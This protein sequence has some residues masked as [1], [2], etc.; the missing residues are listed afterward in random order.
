MED[1]L[2]G[3]KAAR[4]AGMRCIAVS[5]GA[6]SKEELGNEY[7]DLI[8][9]SIG[10]TETILGFILKPHNSLPFDKCGALSSK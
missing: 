6:Y 3:M 10:E 8:I 5:T 2:F 9:D 4:Q 1:S 7:S